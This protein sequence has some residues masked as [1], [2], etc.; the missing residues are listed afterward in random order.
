MNRADRPVLITAQIQAA[1]LEAQ[2]E[3]ISQTLADLVADVRALQSQLRQGEIEKKTETS[4]LLNDLRYW[5]KAARET[6]AEL[7]EIRRKESGI[8]DAYGLDLEAAE[9]AIGC[10][11]AQ[12]R[13][14]CG[15]GEVSE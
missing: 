12:L 10:R 1:R 3:E 14:C 8:G 4:K 15:A 5:L 7:E 2:R 11:M 6:E 9:F 13:P